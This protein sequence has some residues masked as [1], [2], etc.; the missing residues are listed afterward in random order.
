MENIWIYISIGGGVLLLLLFFFIFQYNRFVRLDKM[1]DEAFS[2]MDIYLVKR[3]ELVPKLVD[4]VKGYMAHEKDT[5]TQITMLR[6]HSYDGMTD[7][8][9]IRT[10]TVLSKNLGQVVAVA[11][12]YPELRSGENY[13][14]LS[15]QLYQ[16]EDEI[17]QSRKYYNGTVRMLNTKVETFPGVL[18][19]R[20][21]GFHS[22][23]MYEA[24]PIQRGDVKVG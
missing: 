21:Y 17:A 15:R 4:T 8:E 14:L 20:L 9:K 23:E 22:R 2:T 13:L 11:E 10:N 19:A 5:L 18:F 1:V 24:S 7:S 12:Q 6:N 16:V 3:W